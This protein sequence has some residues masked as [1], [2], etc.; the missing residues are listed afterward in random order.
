MGADRYGKRD[1]TA[2][3]TIGPSM[4][5]VVDNASK[6]MKVYRNGTLIRTIPVSMGRPRYPTPSGTFLVMD[7]R[8]SMIFDSSTWGLP[9]DAP[10][11]YRT[12]VLWD[13]R[14]TWG[15]VFIHAAPW[16]VRQQ[17]HRNVSHGCINVSTK[18]ARWYF[19]MAQKGDVVQIVGTEMKATQGDGWTDWNMSWSQFRAG[20]ALP[21]AKAN[22]RNIP[23]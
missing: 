10:G 7:K 19:G 1:R 23:R 3:F 4:V 12:T 11:G 9:I 17:G 6:A 14:I 22:S 13:V 21:T 2:K 20:S 18:N 5:S 15:G 8:S 16:S